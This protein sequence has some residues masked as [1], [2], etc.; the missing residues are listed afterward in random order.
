MASKETPAGM[1]GDG[2]AG[3]LGRRLRS[4]RTGRGMTLAAV[5]Q[6]TGVASSSL[7][8]IEN[9]QVS[10]SYHTLKRICDG[11]DIPIEEIINPD[12][13]KFAPGRR[14]ITRAADG[15]EFGCPQYIYRAHATDM[16]KK[17]MIPLEMTVLARKPEDFDDWN[18]HEGEEF[19]YV[20]SGVVDM[21]TEFYAPTR[22]VAGESLYFDSAMGHMFISVSEEDARIL[23]I[24]YDPRAHM[25]DDILDFFRA[26]RLN[27]QPLADESV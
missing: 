22:L 2:S 12:H 4:W 11:L 18:K 21:Y 20:L 7:S 1:K 14:S 16:S 8:K 19:V 17:E 13:K 15:S 10:V 24:C 26:G 27:V 6:K 25:Q 9:E 5:S 3:Q 23:S